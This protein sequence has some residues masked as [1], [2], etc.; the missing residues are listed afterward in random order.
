MVLHWVLNFIQFWKPTVT[1][2]AELWSSN[3][4]AKTQDVISSDLKAIFT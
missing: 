2:R 4:L 1:R 3:G